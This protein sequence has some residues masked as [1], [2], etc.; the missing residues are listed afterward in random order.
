M[1][2]PYNA[3]HRRLRTQVLAQERYCVG[4]PLGVHGRMLVPTTSLDHIVPLVRGGGSARSQV[5]A[6]CGACNSRKGTDE[7]VRTWRSG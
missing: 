1:S 6:L 3:A 2:T 7:R 5:R 4:Y